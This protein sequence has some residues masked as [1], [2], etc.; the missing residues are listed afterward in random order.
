LIEQAG[1][2]LRQVFSRDI[3]TSQAVGHEDLMK[4]L[5]D[6]FGLGRDLWPT[7]ALRQLWESV[8]SAADG[9][10][11]TPG[12]E[13]RWM[14]LAG[15]CLRPGFGYPHDDFRVTQLWRLAHTGP[16]FDR[17]EPCRVQ[18]WIMSR[19]IAAGLNASQ[20]EVLFSRIA[21]ALLPS[22]SKARKT[23]MGR[24]SAHE[25]VE[26]W[27]LGAS[28]SRI[29]A[30]SKI[31]LG[32]ALLRKLRRPPYAQHMLWAVARIGA[33]VPIYGP[34][35]AVVDCT[36]VASWIEQLL[37]LDEPNPNSHEAAAYSF[38]LSLLARRSGDRHRDIT[39]ELRGRVIDR[40]A[41]LRAREHL[42]RLVSEVT[43]LDRVEQQIA[44]GESL[45]AGL[46]IVEHPSED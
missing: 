38:T 27:R 28:L 4:S 24:P 22:G 21:P 12:H 40:L 19:R 16:V 43:V 6:L 36:I 41:K 35:H 46:R 32:Q 18:W 45:P 25:L 9:R 3:D 17:D 7:S 14:N 5:R 2:L 23:S 29:A 34:V 31:E 33:R 39:D 8:A 26:I 15:F 20:Q 10:K 44:F 37:T 13:R 1:V 30:S 42:I 11:R